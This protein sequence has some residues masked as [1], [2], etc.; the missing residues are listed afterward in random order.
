MARLTR[1]RAPRE[2]AG[3]FAASDQ[4]ERLIGAAGTRRRPPRTRAGQRHVGRDWSHQYTFEGSAEDVTSDGSCE[5]WG[6]S[7][8]RK[9]TLT[10]C[11]VALVAA[12]GGAAYVFTQDDELQ[13][14]ASPVDRIAEVMDCDLRTSG[15]SFQFAGRA[16]Q[17]MCGR[18]G[19]DEALVHSF[20][21]DRRADV[22]RYL[23][24]RLAHKTLTPCDDGSHP[25]GGPWILVGPTWAVSSYHE[26][27]VRAVAADLGGEFVGGGATEDDPPIG[28]PVSYYSTPGICD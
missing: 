5:D 2:N 16:E 17:L 26:A 4:R 25:E 6:M 18:D 15:V 22:A 10:A 21:V 19:T 3:Y 20:A 11:G 27:E 1:R 28:P 7:K 13:P 24:Q 8:M 9:I 23:G 12:I 14:S